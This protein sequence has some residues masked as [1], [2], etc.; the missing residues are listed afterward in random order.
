MNS[1]EFKIWYV[2]NHAEPLA[3]DREYVQ[4]GGFNFYKFD[5]NDRFM[6]KENESVFI[7]NE[8]SETTTDIDPNFKIETICMEDVK[9][10]YHLDMLA[11]LNP[12]LPIWEISFEKLQAFRASVVEL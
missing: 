4:V 6:T 3:S 10:Q 5:V 2:F 1:E 8:N 11:M 12:H 7:F 9:S